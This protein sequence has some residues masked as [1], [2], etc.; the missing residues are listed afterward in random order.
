MSIGNRNDIRINNCNLIIQ[1]R[2]VK[3]AYGNINSQWS[4]SWLCKWTSV[5]HDTISKIVTES[6]KS[7]NRTDLW[8]CILHTQTYSY[9]QTRSVTRIFIQLTVILFLNVFQK[10]AKY[11]IVIRISSTFCYLWWLRYECYYFIVII[12]APIFQMRPKETMVI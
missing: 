8:L 1:I 7:S 2:T 5:I 10:C 6:I 12:I 11:A 3:R 9:C 4:P